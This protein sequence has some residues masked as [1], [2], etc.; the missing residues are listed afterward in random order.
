MKRLFFSTLLAL[1]MFATGGLYRPAFAQHAHDH[2]A[3]GKKTF[4]GHI[5]CA[6]CYLSHGE[7]GAGHKPCS[8]E[9]AKAGIP[10]AI[11]DTESKTLYLPLAKNHHAPANTELMAYVEQDVTVTGTVME[12]DGL[13]AIVIEKIEPVKK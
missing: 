6:A 4:K 9:C 2:A 7:M 13:K 10:M 11:L 8:T 3:A 5:V 12:R 1:C